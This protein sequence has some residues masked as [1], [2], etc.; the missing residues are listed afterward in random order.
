VI[1]TAFYGFADYLLTVDKDIL[2]PPI[3][4]MLYAYGIEIL[5]ANVLLERLDNLQRTQRR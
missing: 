2:D 3:V 1:A 5:S 4:E